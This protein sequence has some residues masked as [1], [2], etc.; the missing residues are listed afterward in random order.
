MSERQIQAYIVSEKT[1]KLL[2]YAIGL[3]AVSLSI[4]LLYSKFIF[5]KVNIVISN[6]SFFKMFF[7]IKIQLL[8]ISTVV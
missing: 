8:A 2:T 5:P 6:C 3:S 1:K 7:Y 4:S